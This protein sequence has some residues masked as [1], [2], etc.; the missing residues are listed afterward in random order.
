MKI[1]RRA[2]G[3]SECSEREGGSVEPLLLWAYRLN[4]KTKFGNKIAVWS[5]GNLKMC[6]LS[7]E[8]FCSLFQDRLDC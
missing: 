5:L 4:H 6:H 3:K 7:V 2:G 8:G 1:G